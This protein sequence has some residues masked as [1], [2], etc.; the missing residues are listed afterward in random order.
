MHVRYNY[1]DI[2]IHFYVGAIY[3]IRIHQQ[4]LGYCLLGYIFPIHHQF[5]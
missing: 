2:R 3:E 4:H 1:Y 5:G